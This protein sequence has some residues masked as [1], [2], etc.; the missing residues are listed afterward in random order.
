MYLFFIIIG[1]VLYCL[2]K[3]WLTC[4]FSCACVTVLFGWLATVIPR[5]IVYYTSTALFAIFGLKMLWEGFHM[6]PGGAQEEMDEVHADLRKHDDEVCFV[7]FLHKFWKGPNLMWSLIKRIFISYCLVNILLFWIWLEC[8]YITWRLCWLLLGCV[9]CSWSW[10]SS[11]GTEVC[12]VWRLQTMPPVT[13]EEPALT[14]RY[15]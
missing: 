13:W 10:L 11:L 15:Y 6:P 14:F 9:F 5:N 3:R 7:L 12:F 8:I 1:F 2:N 4:T